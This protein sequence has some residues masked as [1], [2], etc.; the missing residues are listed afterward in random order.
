MFGCGACWRRWQSSRP[1]LK[2]GADGWSVDLPGARR[3]R[4]RSVPA[5]H[6]DRRR[7]PALDHPAG[8]ILLFIVL[9]ALVVLLAD[10]VGGCCAGPTRL[11]AADPARRP[12]H[13]RPPTILVVVLLTV[14]VIAIGRIF[15]ML[16]MD[17]DAL[18]V[19]TLPLS[20]LPYGHL[21]G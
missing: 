7:D 11:A 4:D 10:K 18:A 16:G 3:G 17:Y 12:G 8:S 1:R 14:L 20:V 5:R 2:A 15:W 21:S 13:G 9:Q 6:P 19:L